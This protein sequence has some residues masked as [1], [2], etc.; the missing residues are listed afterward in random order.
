MLKDDITADDLMK[1]CRCALEAKNHLS[2]RELDDVECVSRG[3]VCL[4]SVV[5]RGERFTAWA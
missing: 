2:I 1:I 3:L 4:E 5:S